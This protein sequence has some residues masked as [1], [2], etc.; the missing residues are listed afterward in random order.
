MTTTIPWCYDLCC[1]LFNFYMPMKATFL[2][3]LCSAAIF[4]SGCATIVSK[5][6]TPV[7]ITSMPTGAIV[8]VTNKKGSEIHSAVTPTTVTLKNG[9]GY[10]Q[11]E[12]Y[13]V[14]FEKDGFQKASQQLDTGLNA[15]YVGNILFG[16]LIG[17]LF[18]DP[19]TGAMWRMDDEVGA[20]MIEA[21]AANTT[22]PPINP[23]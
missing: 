10:F 20:A 11:G 12:T 23:S 18:V 6:Q 15:W 9:A 13:T 21:P 16:G 8:K 5:S 17:I 14:S 3:S 2:F 7:T 4:M 19:I 22:S 1:S